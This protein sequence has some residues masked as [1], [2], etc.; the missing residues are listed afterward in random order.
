M[1]PPP[2]LPFFPGTTTQTEGSRNSAPIRP[3]AFQRGAPGL[4]PGFR[5][6][7]RKGEE[8][9]EEK[10]ADNLTSHPGGAGRVRGMNGKRME[11]K[12]IANRE[13]ESI[14]PSFRNC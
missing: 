8:E 14:H 10:K 7:E 11:G 13:H 3:G 9:E 2:P 5:V 6:R 12:D 1:P 4:G